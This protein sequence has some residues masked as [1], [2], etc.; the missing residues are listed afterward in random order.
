M[1]FLQHLNI[2]SKKLTW[3]ERVAAFVVQQR[4]NNSWVVAFVSLVVGRQP[5]VGSTYA[6]C[7]NA[8]F[9]R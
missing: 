3:R 6:R 1:S 5:V 2:L 9:T 8:A 7:S 4:G